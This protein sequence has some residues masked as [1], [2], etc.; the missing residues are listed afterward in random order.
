MVTLE[1]LTQYS[2]ISSDSQRFHTAWVKSDE[3]ATV[4][5]RPELGDKRT[6]LG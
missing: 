5:V 1:Q 4:P 3:K 6:K 2:L